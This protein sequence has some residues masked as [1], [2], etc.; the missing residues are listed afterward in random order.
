MRL[1]CGLIRKVI[2]SGRVQV[3]IG[4]AIREGSKELD[5]SN[6]TKLRVFNYMSYEFSLGH[7]WSK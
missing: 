5:L 3:G 4:E 6:H 1:C 7:V 2:F